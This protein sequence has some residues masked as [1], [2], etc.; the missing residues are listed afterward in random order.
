MYVY[1]RLQALEDV[2]FTE[3]AA[4]IADYRKALAEQVLSVIY[5]WCAYII[6]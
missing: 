3:K 6:N 4:K 5:I 1:W 2:Y